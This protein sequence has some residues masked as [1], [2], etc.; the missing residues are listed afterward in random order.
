MGVSGDESGEVCHIH[1]EDCANFVGDLPHAGEVDDAWIGTAAAHN[2]L[3]MFAL[4]DLLEF[5]VV[6]GFCVFGYAVGNDLVS[7]AAEVQVMTVSEV[8]AMRQVKSEDSIARLDDGTV[9]FHV[10]G[11]S[12]MRLHVGVLSAEKSFGAIARKVLDDVGELASAV[13]TL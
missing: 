6:D 10:G 8:S 1:H 13:I 7:L 9:G 4:G 12:G 5:V 11:G 2:Q 3:G